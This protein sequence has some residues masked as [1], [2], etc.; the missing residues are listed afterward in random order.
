[1]PSHHIPKKKSCLQSNRDSP[2]KGLRKV[3]NQVNLLRKSSQERGHP[4][5]PLKGDEVS[6]EKEFQKK[7]RKEERHLELLSQD[8]GRGRERGEKR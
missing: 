8:R 7:S 4:L 6:D 1:V 2:L 3:G 5:S